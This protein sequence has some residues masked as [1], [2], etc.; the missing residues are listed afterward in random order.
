MDVGLDP[1]RGA[2]VLTRATPV[3]AAQLDG[4]PAGGLG[5][6][7]RVRQRRRVER[8]G[9][10]R[11]PAHAAPSALAALATSRCS[12]Q[13]MAPKVPPPPHTASAAV[14]LIFACASRVISSATA[15]GRSEPLTRSAF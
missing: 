12:T 5:G 9:V 6:G 13:T 7:H 4:V 11:Q 3:G 15:P 14:T 1:R 10:K 8:P 2:A